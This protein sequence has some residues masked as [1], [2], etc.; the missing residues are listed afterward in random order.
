MSVDIYL[1]DCSTAIEYDGRQHYDPK[2]FGHNAEQFM[3]T[4]ERDRVKGELLHEH[5][6]RLIRVSGWPVDIEALVRK[7]KGE[8]SA[9]V[10]V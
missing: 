7:I 4:Q 10:T 5:N 3:V 6:I 9:I 1:P 8:A 2:A